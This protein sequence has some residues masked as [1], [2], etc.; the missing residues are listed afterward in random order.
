MEAQE[1]LL[2]QQVENG[3]LKQQ[4]EFLNSV[5][6]DLQVGRWGQLVALVDQQLLSTPCELVFSSVVSTCYC[7]ASWKPLKYWP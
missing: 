4:I 7:S 1:A 3:D 6:S 2:K 5:I